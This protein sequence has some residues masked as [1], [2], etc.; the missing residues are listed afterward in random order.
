MVNPFYPSVSRPGH[1]TI[2]LTLLHHSTPVLQT[3]SYQYPLKLIAPSA[4]ALPSTSSSV[5]EIPP[6]PTFVHSV[7]LLTY[8]G[9]LVAGDTVELNLNLDRSTRL[10]LLTQG[11]TKIFKSPSLDITSG[12]RMYASLASGSGL[13]YLPDPVQPFAR[14]CFEQVQVY[15][16]K[17]ADASMCV[18]D[19]VCEGRTAR[20]EKW[21]C[22]RYR[23]KNEVYSTQER[24]GR[25]L[26]LR[27]NVMLDES[28]K[29]K[30]GLMGRMDGLGVFGT[31][32]L[33]GPLFEHLGK[34]FMDEFDRLP[35]IG[36]RKWDEGFEEKGFESGESS[37][38]TRQEQE[39]RDG[40]L[41]T[42][43]TV[44]SFVVVKFGARQVE[45]ARRW[46]SH[47]L[48]SEGSVEKGFGE[49]ALFCLG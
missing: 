23:S 34:Y 32:I 18:L 43:A 4:I 13:C 38:K 15:E 17:G 2:T 8:G 24:R 37:R 49:R 21:D 22:W 6:Y 10:L 40:L 47:M 16:L 20:G 29:M 28:G 48:K 36:A 7:F 19:W 45:G 31:L 44:R 42:A 1:G 26:L 3:L 46:L 35:R 5:S 41:W 25:R 27:D 30:I 11:S 39:S 9:G 14:S 33:H 12:Q